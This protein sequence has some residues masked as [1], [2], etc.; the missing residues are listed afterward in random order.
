MM[1][2]LV[3]LLAIKM[4]IFK[5]INKFRFNQ[6]N[7]FIQIQRNLVVKKIVNLY[8]FKFLLQNT[9]NFLKNQKLIHKIFQ[10]N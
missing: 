6:K 1:I 3:I 9:H 2:L 5:R 8:S 10:N 4:T 7:L